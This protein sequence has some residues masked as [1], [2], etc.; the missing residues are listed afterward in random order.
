MQTGH[1]GLK[2]VQSLHIGASEFH[3]KFFIFSLCSNQG[4]KQLDFVAVV[5]TL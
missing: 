2:L 1:H 4:K 5:F 3:G